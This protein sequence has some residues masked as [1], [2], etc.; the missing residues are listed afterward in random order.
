MNPWDRSGTA[1]ED[2][3]T[4]GQS[5]IAPRAQAGG[6]PQYLI[7]APDSARPPPP[8]LRGL[9]PIPATGRICHMGTRA[10]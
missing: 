3:S 6:V 8:E 5:R 10:P 2:M 1:V 9:T 7:I 4:S